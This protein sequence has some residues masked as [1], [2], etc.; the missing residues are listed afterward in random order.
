MYT[1]CRDAAE[2]RVSMRCL[3]TCAPQR[4]STCPWV[5]KRVTACREGRRGYHGKQVRSGPM[6]T[7]RTAGR[8]EGR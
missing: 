3:G 2:L 5:G 8:C 6:S 1:G 4:T 7:G